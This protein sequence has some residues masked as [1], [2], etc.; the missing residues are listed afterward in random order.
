MKTML[1]LVQNE[2]FL[3]FCPLSLKAKRGLKK[4]RSPAFSKIKKIETE[5]LPII[6]QK[7][8]LSKP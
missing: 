6:K 4:K 2:A 8:H 3:T 5:S 1:L 7:T